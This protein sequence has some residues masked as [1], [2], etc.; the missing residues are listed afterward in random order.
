MGNTSVLLV[1][2]LNY[3]WNVTGPEFHDYH[4][5]FDQQYNKLFADMDKIA[6][7]VRALKGHAVGSLHHV[8]QHATLQEDNGKT[9]KPKQMVQNLTKQYEMLISEIK[10]TISELNESS[11]DFGTINFLEELIT[12]HEKTAW[13][14]RSLVNKE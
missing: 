14:L 7:R 12:Q 11:T 1:Q 3:H 4:L 2:T 10:D 5:L 8:L 9:P 13:M 6:E